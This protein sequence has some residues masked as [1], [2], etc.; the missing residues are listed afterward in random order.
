MITFPSRPF[1]RAASGY[2]T[3]TSLTIFRVLPSES[4]TRP[5]AWF[6]AGEGRVTH[7]A[8]RPAASKRQPSKDVLSI[9]ADST[10]QRPTS[11]RFYYHSV[12]SACPHLRPRDFS[13]SPSRH[14][15]AKKTLP[16]KAA[17]WGLGDVYSCPDDTPIIQST[18]NRSVSMPNFGDQ[19]V[20]A[21]GAFTVPPATS[22]V[23]TLSASASLEALK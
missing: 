23:N 6:V 16:A 18:P 11:T 14:R 21:K 3:A 12:N 5:T 20:G 19:K 1:Q 9:S 17:F 2:A 13:L 22:A 15:F 10:A 7:P 8:M 4:K